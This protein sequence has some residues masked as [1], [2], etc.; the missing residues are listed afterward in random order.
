[1]ATKKSLSKKGYKKGGRKTNGR[2][3]RGRKVRKTYKKNMKGGA[4]YIPNAVEL[5]DGI[6]YVK[7]ETPV[8]TP[9]EADKMESGLPKWKAVVQDNLG[10]LVGAMDQN[11]TLSTQSFVHND[12]PFNC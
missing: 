3:T 1:M 4:C 6:F 12:Y 10:K 5:N 11:K 2:K 9:A 8:R 7:G